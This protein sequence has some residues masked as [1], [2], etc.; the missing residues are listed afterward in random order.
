MLQSNGVQ[1]KPLLDLEA[2]RASLRTICGRYS[3]QGVEH[4]AFQGW[5]RTLNVYGLAA[6]D[7]GWNARRIERTCRDVRLDGMEHYYARIQLSGN[8]AM[9]QNDQA[10]RIAAGDVVL[11]DAA[12]PVT[13]FG[14]DASARWVSLHLPRQSLISYLGFQPEGALADAAERRPDVS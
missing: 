6:V 11:V 5:A 14:N 3:P 4:R 10:L 13:Y 1:A 7:V 9:I 12:R 8:S 2:W